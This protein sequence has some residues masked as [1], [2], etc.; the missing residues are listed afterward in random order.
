[1]G[2]IEYC[3][4]I[5]D[6]YSEKYVYDNFVGAGASYSGTFNTPEEAELA[7]LRKLIEIVKKQATMSGGIFEY[8]QYKIGYIA[9]SIQSYIDNSGRLKTEEEKHY[10]YP[11]EILEKFREAVYV[12]RQAEVYAQRVDRFLSGDDGEENFLRRL[13]EDLSKIEKQ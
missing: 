12:L 11:P 1:M 4:Q 10:E 7:C 13:N 5:R 3:F 6:L 2:A 9:E 8:D